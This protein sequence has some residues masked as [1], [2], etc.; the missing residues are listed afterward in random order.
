MYKCSEET[1]FAIAGT[2]AVDKRL[3]TINDASS[4]QRVR[5]QSA[6]STLFVPMRLASL[7]EA[8]EDDEAN[9]ARDAR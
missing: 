5:W 7:A 4:H 9:Y 2:V 3:V 8:E 6:T 1:K